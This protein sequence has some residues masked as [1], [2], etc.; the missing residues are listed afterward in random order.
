MTSEFFSIVK[1]RNCE[2]LFTNP[3]PDRTEIS[4]YYE[5]NDYISHS[6]SNKG[7]TNKIYRSVRKYSI[8]KKIKLLERYLGEKNK[9]ILDIGCGTGEFLGACKQAGWQSIGIEP[10]EGA[11][12]KAIQNFSLNVYPE[13]YLNDLKNTGNPSIITMWHVLEHVHDL[14]VRMEQVSSILQKGG[15]LIIAVPNPE[16]WDANHYQDAWAAYDVPRH[17]YHFTP[18]VLRKFVS[19]FQFTYLE[20]HPMLFDSFYVSMLSEKYQHNHANLFNAVFSGLKS[21]LNAGSNPEKY[22]S[23]IYV[24]KK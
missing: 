14:R 18:S 12:N 24:F 10:N 1:C 8:Q 15:I 19:T 17:L 5:S 16:S 21:N 20:S 23:V 7:L 13:T 22:S 4:R 11:R 6:N 3:R 9:S 2:L